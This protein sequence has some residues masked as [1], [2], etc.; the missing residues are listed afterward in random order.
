MEG[1]ILVAE[2]AITHRTDL[3]D[4]LDSAKE[5]NEDTTGVAVS[6]VCVLRFT[7]M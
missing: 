1:K 6:T 5:L 3:K 4:T 2:S 7:C